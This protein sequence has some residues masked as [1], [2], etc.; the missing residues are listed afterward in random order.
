MF[1]LRSCVRIFVAFFGAKSLDRTSSSVLPYFRTLLR[2]ARLNFRAAF[3]L[4]FGRYC[5]LRSF[6]SLSALIAVAIDE[7]SP[8][9]MFWG[10]MATEKVRFS[11]KTVQN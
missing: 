9:I 2:S 8:F 11:I 7:F 5:A 10:K 3:F 6:F 4:I 1:S